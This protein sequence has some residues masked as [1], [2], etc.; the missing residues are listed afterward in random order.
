MDRDDYDSWADVEQ[1]REEN[2]FSRNM[3]DNIVFP[4]DFPHSVWYGKQQIRNRPLIK[5]EKKL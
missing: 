5:K 2:S 4:S 3:D 1:Q